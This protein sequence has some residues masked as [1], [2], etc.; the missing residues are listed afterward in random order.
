M[1]QYIISYRGTSGLSGVGK[2][3]RH[4]IDIKVKNKSQI[5]AKLDDMFDEVEK[6]LCGIKVYKM[7]EVT[8]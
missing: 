3:A 4:V 6:K 7:T 1:E 5:A 8:I 2:G